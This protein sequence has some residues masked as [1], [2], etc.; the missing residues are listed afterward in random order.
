MKKIYALCFL[1]TSMIVTPGVAF[2]G[3][4]QSSSDVL[5]QTSVITGSG[6]SSN[7]HGS[8]YTS[9]F[10]HKNGA[11]PFCS[12]SGSQSQHSQNTMNQGSF[13]AGYGNSSTISGSQTTNQAQINALRAK[14]C[15]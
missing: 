4:S 6:N 8:Q 13:I 1:A 3:Q 12:G 9:Q 15:R 11:Y 10:Q 7:I 14:Y 5:N 2:A